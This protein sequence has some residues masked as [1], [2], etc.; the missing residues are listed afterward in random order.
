VIAADT[1]GDAQY[2]MER[3][4]IARKAAAIARLIDVINHKLISYKR[5]QT[6]SAKLI[7][8]LRQSKLI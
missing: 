6:L 8:T 4:S 5:I 2:R 1:L 3:I 7:M